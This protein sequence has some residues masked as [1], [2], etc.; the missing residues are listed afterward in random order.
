MFCRAIL[1]G[2]PLLAVEA[3]D[4]SLAQEEGSPHDYIPDG[5]FP[6]VIEDEVEEHWKEARGEALL[7]KTFKIKEPIIN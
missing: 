4:D 3:N 1:A 7:K 2:I 6:T 5:P